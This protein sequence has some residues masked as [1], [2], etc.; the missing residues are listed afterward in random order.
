MGYST[1]DFKNLT[2]DK[3][4]RSLLEKI[5]GTEG[6]GSS[7]PQTSK[8]IAAAKKTANAD[9]NSSIVK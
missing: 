7:D 5:A 3:K 6:E 4:F 9:L 2:V 8:A 1:A